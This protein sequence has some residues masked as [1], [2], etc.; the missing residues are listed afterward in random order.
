MTRSRSDVR[1]GFAAPLTGDQAI[2]GVPMAQC[3]E[4][5]VALANEEGRSPY[6][7]SL[8]A[9]DDQADPAA[10]AGVARRLC[11]DERVIGVVG[12]KNSGPSA[13]AAPVYHAAR[14]AQV[15][16]SSTNPTLSRRGWTTFFR[17]CAQD[18][19]QGTVAARF[20]ARTLGAR[21]VL[22]VHDQTDYGWPLAQ[23]F[24]AAAAGL[25]LTVVRV[26]A[27]QVGTTDFATTL[28]GIRSLGP[29]L[30]YCALTEIEASALARQARAGGAT[31]T[32]LA[33]DGGPESKFLALGGG[34]AEGSYHTYAGAVLEPSEP[35]RAFVDAF[36]A[37]FGQPVP[38]YGG[39][40]YDAARVLIA[41]LEQAGRPD[42]EAVV[43]ALRAT[44]LAGVTGRVRF[45][46]NGDR[47][48]LEVTIWKVDRGAC[49]LLGAARD[50]APA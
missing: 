3:A 1:I 40:S 15:S 45:E 6:R 44:D 9:V 20:A 18:T 32:M 11:A 31:V 47:R 25:G 38:P 4:L 35:V 34:A 28:A 36:Q 5:A 49:R 37:R 7:L 29:D 21:R 13:A 43:A 46:P 42:R 30:V 14:V 41:A 2:V 10:S 24:G 27:V 17:V 39:E 22:I 33:T 48:D 26:D 23:A 8:Q 16:P 50:L 19:L 12:H